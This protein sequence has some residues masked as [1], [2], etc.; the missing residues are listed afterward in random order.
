MKIK[1]ET[2][3]LHAAIRSANTYLDNAHQH[4]LQHPKASVHMDVDQN[5]ELA[6]S[7]AIL[8]ARTVLNNALVSDG[9]PSADLVSFRADIVTAWR[10]T[11]RNGSVPASS[12]RFI[13]TGGELVLMIEK[14]VPLNRVSVEV[15]VPETPVPE[16]VT[17]PAIGEAAQTELQNATV[18]AGLPATTDEIAKI[19]E[20][21]A[22]ESNK[23]AASAATTLADVTST[24]VIELPTP[25]DTQVGLDNPLEEVKPADQDETLEGLKA[26]AGA[27]VE[28]VAV[29]APVD[30]YGTLETGE[31]VNPTVEVKEA[32]TIE[33][34]AP[35]D[36]TSTSNE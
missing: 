6:I 22:N 15:V 17:P 11:Y 36:F 10:A 7:N 5:A 9:I 4:R 34:P 14:A 16:E 35:L 24:A 31:V 13:I 3:R 26:L 25:V 23:E 18:G 33:A 30:A 1:T 27:P 29:P 28:D 21:V 19:N 12:P 2:S 32:E 20:A 8:R